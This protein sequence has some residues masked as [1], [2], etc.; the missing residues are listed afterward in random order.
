MDRKT[1]TTSFLVGLSAGGGV[2][3]YF[4]AAARERALR[5]KSELLSEVERLTTETDALR[6]E[7]AREREANE[8]LTAQLSRAR[9]RIAEFSN[10]E[11]ELR[12]R[13]GRPRAARSE[14]P[15]R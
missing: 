6:A 14:K 4:A 12:N 3:A 2:A 13:L 7:A 10:L 1:K 15:P 9:S 5:E 11:T 8:R